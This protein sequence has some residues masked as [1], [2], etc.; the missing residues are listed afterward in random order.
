MVGR[1]EAGRGRQRHRFAWPVGA[2]SYRFR[3]P[4]GRGGCCSNMIHSSASPLR[5]TD[6]CILQSEKGGCAVPS[7]L[8]S[9]RVWARQPA[10]NNRGWPRRSCGTA[11]ASTHGP[12]TRMPGACVSTNHQTMRF[13]LLLCSE[14]RG[15]G[16]TASGQ[17]AIPTSTELKAA[18][19]VASLEQ[20]TTLS[21]DNELLQP[22]LLLSLTCPLRLPHVVLFNGQPELQRHLL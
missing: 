20:K 3:H 11:F 1:S 17:S 9:V 21:P 18:R 12:G 22:S 4:L 13:T 2:S 8:A 5:Q 15:A 14:H 7:R 6:P 19:G 10:S 16:V